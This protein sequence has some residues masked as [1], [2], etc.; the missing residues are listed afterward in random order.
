MT[1]DD[2]WLAWR[3]AWGDALTG[4][5]PHCGDE[6]ERF[7]DPAP[8]LCAMCEKAGRVRGGGA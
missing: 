7:E 1:E 4:R 3:D 8:D 6:T 5:C 2:V